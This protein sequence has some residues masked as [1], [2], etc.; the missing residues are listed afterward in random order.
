[1]DAPL[2]A[3]D[4]SL[5]QAFLA[6]AEEGSLSGAARALGA[7]QPTLGRQI[8]AIERQLGADLFHRRPR[9]LEPTATGAALIGPA[10]AMRDAVQQIALTA[11]GREA[12]MAGTVR[13]TA[14]VAMSMHHL[15]RI[16]AAIRAA[17][18]EIRIELVPSDES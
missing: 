5:V 14:S 18:P 4:W 1:M 7:S 3:L 9:G 13:I 10:R 12:R 8:R 17:E 16:V 11:A 6:V 15:P 2:A